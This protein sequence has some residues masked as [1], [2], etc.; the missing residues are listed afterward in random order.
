M[1]WIVCIT[2]LD[3]RYEEES[4]LIE[5]EAWERSGQ[6]LNNGL[7]LKVDFRTVRI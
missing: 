7:A 3:G 5:E 4:Y 2:W 1:K 6:L